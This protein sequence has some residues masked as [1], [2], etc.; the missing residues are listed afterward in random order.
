MFT[1]TWLYVKEHNVTGL[2][3]LG[4]TTADPYTYQGSGVHWTNHIKKHGNDVTTSWAHLYNDPAILQNEALFFS[5]VFDVVNSSKW[6]NLMVE[7]GFTGG[8]TYIRTPEHNLL[9]SEATTGKKMPEGFGEKVRKNKAGVKKPNFGKIISA[10]LKGNSKPVGFGAK[11]SDALTGLPKSSTH[12]L[13]LSESIKNIP[14]IKCEHCGA[15]LSPGNHKRWHGNN[16]K[17]IK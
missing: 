3:Y 2:K 5:K 12:K 15:L 16:C 8:N 1:P 14:K 11:V 7:D 4:K 10:K 6:A 13:N 9:M 17:G